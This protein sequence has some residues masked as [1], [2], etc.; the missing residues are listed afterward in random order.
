MIT[1]W[2]GCPSLN[3]TLYRKYSTQ[4]RGFFS[5]CIEQSLNP[6]TQLTRSYTALTLQSHLS[7][8]LQLT[9]L[10]PA[11]FQVG[12]PGG[13]VGEESACNAGDAGLIPGSGRS[14][15]GGHGNPLQSSCLENPMEREAWWATLCAVT[16]SDTTETTEHALRCN[17]FQLL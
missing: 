10:H 8:L 7:P 3:A 11:R 9:S 16:K 1:W 2:L 4:D 13:S 5:G 15:W 14:P 17:L 12:F 6:S